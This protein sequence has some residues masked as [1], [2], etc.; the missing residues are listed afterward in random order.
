MALA[1][2]SKQKRIAVRRGTHDC[3]RSNIAASAWPVVD[4]ELLAETLR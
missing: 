2:S 3:F 4:N 1:E